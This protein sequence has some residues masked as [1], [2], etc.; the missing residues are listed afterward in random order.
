[1]TRGQAKL[2]VLRAVLSTVS[3]YL[4]WFSFAFLSIGLFTSIQNLY[5]LLTVITAYFVLHESLGPSEI[6]NMVISFGAVLLIIYS[7]NGTG[8][9]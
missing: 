6:V 9:G 1:V 7:A 4:M 8:A 3:N 5:P 2:L